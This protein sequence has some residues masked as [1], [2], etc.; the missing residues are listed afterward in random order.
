[1]NAYITLVD[2]A[3]DGARLGSKA[4]TDDQIRNLVIV[5]TE[6]LRDPVATGD[7]SITHTILDGEDAIRVQVCNDRT[8]ILSVPLIM[9]DSFQMCSTTT[10]RVLGSGT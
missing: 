5:E 9:P 4:V 6:R 3:R 8:L 2:A 7:I 10:M 1:L